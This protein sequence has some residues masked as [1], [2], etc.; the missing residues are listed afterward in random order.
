MTL[1]FE[2]PLVS[3]VFLTILSIVFF[4]KRKIALKENSIYGVIVIFSLIVSILDTILHFNGAMNNYET[5]IAK[6]YNFANIMNKFITISF[7]IIFTCLLLYILFITYEKL[8]IK[9]KKIMKAFMIFDILCFI[10]ILFT[11]IK[12]YKIGEVTNVAGSTITFTYAVIAV[13]LI[14]TLI[15]SFINIRRLDKRYIPIFSLIFL[16]ISFY[17]L[18]IA[19]PGIIIYDLILALMCYIMYFTIE[20]PDLKMVNELLRNRELIEDQMEDKSDFL[21]EMSQGIKMPAKN[22]LE[23]TKTYDKL[24]EDIDKKDVITNIQA[25]ANELIFRTNN[26]LDVSSMD[27]SKIKIVDDDYNPY[28]LFNEIKSFVNNKLIDKKIE[29]NFKVNNNV[30]NRLCGD[31][32]RLKQILMSV[33]INSIENTNSG[34]INVNIDS[35]TRYDV[36][37]LIIKV[38]D[39]GFGMDIN[40]VNKILDSSRNLSIEEIEKLDKLDVDMPAAIKI[41]KLLGG[42][43][44]IRSNIGKGTIINIVID[45]RYKLDEVTS[46]KK[47]I[48]KYSSDV[49]GRK[50]VLVVND[51]KEELFKIKTILSK[52]NYDVN[53]T[54]IG[55]E[56]ID[57]IKSGEL[58]NL[59]IIDDDLRNN[60]ALEILKEIKKDK[61][62]N[63]NVIV[64]LEKEKEHFKNN[65]IEEGFNDYILKENMSEDLEKIISKYL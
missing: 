65:Y 40:K 25:N 3:T 4:S 7:I 33:L 31:S 29:L 37:R 50:R 5:I 16:L 20:N 48:E 12:V 2:L 6:Y 26:I 42:N 13:L 45:Q 47:D 56:C 15:I 51:D 57:K 63:S 22:I 46:I 17:V 39:S 28:A 9:F 52:Y 18:T 24:E 30:P 35:I 64:T 43:I 62:F 11:N 41:I 59:V 1:E 8:R 10:I 38:E 58:Y 14:V 23:L 19:F 36:A 21:F 53:S 54:M 60:S 32:I 61:K 49:Y 27:A 44:N 55:K 34:Y